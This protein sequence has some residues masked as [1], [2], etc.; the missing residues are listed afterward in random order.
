MVEW[1]EEKDVGGGSIDNTEGV[2]ALVGA[3]VKVGAGVESESSLISI[4]VSLDCFLNWALALALRF[5]NHICTPLGV[6]SN[7]SAKSLRTNA[8]GF[9]LDWKVSSSIYKYVNK[10]NTTMKTTKLTLNWC[11]EVLFLCLTSNGE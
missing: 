5:W 10:T 3:G 9:W 4:E 1:D 7:C 6:I 11:L 2:V 8:E